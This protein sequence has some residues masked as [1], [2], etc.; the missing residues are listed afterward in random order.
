M[1]YYLLDGRACEIDEHIM[2]PYSTQIL[3]SVHSI[4]PFYTPQTTIEHIESPRE[5]LAR[6]ASTPRFLCNGKSLQA[7]FISQGGDFSNFIN[8][9]SLLK[10]VFLSGP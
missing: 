5:V 8:F 4:L 10:Y 6:K 9:M 3:P 7:M 2:K 1:D